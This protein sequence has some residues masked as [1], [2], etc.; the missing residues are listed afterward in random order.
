MQTRAA[1][2]SFPLEASQEELPF[3]FNLPCVA[4]GRR[5]PPRGGQAGRA[6]PAGEELLEGATGWSS[7]REHQVAAGREEAGPHES[8]MTG[9]G[10]A[11]GLGT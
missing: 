5:A 4:G 10:A 8:F 3:S 7:G 1:A 11:E 2:S 6:L 9:S